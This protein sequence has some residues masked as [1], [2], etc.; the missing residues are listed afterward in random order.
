M[1]YLDVGLYPVRAPTRLVIASCW[2]G[3]LSPSQWQEV[4]KRRK[5]ESLRC[6]AR[7]YGVSHEAVRRA[8][9]LAQ[10]P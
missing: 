5:T 7:E 10:N 2:N 9:S 8:L 4:T 1:Q 3:K 6:L